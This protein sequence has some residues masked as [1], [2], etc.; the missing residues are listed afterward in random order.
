MSSVLE[1]KIRIY[2]ECYKSKIDLDDL[3]LIKESE[4]VKG[5][6]VFPKKRRPKFRD[7]K[8]FITTEEQDGYVSAEDEEKDAED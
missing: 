1:R 7:F 4:I 3:A 2:F 8:E 6:L 5:V